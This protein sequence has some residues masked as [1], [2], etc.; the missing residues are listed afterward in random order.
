MPTADMKIS[1]LRDALTIAALFFAVSLISGGW[2]LAQKA[3]HTKL[4]RSGDSAIGLTIM[5]T[6]VPAGSGNAVALIK[7]A[8]TGTVKAVKTGYQI[9]AKAYVVTEV[10]AKYIIVERPDKTLL[11]IFQDKFAREFNS[12][13]VAA[14]PA[15][16]PAGGETGDTY[17]E[18]G[19]ERNRDQIKM[20]SNYRDRLVNQDLAKV[21]MQATAEPAMENGA[22]VGF[23]FTQIDQD[24]IYAKSGIQDND[25]ITGI[26]GQKLNSVSEAVTLLKSLKQ[27]DQMEIEY[28]RSGSAQ[29]VQINVN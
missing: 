24:S 16:G 13:L 1:S 2:L 27:A 7:E 8:A 23:K 19:F 26:N 5:G 12:G 15:K 20:S 14:D 22:L 29:R 9:L 17:R 25:V 10:H 6:I 11:L 28:K 3:D 21:L 18:D 4:P